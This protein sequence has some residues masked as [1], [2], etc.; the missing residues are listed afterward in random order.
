MER[1]GV[2][3]SGAV[4]RCVLF[5]RFMGKIQETKEDQALVA[6][7]CNPSYRPGR[8][9]EDPKTLSQKYPIHTQKGLEE[10]LRW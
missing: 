1:H 2:D 10:W 7:T 5:C 3:P 8:D 6:H 9:Q 4:L